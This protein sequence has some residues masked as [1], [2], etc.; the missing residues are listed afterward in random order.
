MS[1]HP[2]A[3]E[4]KAS[5]EIARVNAGSL[6]DMLAKAALVNSTRY[7]IGPIRLAAVYPNDPHPRGIPYLGDL[8]RW[9]R[10]IDS[11][12]ES[13]SDALKE[14]VRLASLHHPRESVVA[15][16]RLLIG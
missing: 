6:S 9:C 14:N 11:A 4:G 7:G 2:R 13:V 16:H 8:T 15:W 1:I 12:M 10:A 5:E 3:F